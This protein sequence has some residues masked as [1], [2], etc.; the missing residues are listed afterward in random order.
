[1]LIRAV[2]LRTRAL[3]LIGGICTSSG[4]VVFRSA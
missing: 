1:L 2:E 3:L 4:A